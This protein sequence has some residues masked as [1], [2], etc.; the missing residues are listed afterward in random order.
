MVGEVKLLRR[1]AMGYQRD[2]ATRRRVTLAAASLTV[3]FVCCSLT[4]AVRT[5]GLEGWGYLQLAAA[6]TIGL[7]AMVEALWAV[8]GI[9]ESSNRLSW[10]LAAQRWSPKSAPPTSCFPIDRP[11]ARIRAGYRAIHIESGTSPLL[12]VIFLLAAI[13]LF[14]WLRLSRLRTMKNHRTPRARQRGRAPASPFPKAY[15]SSAPANW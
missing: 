10:L 14:S 9:D 1:L 3:A 13:Y 6:I 15:N 12:P 8:W 11:P 2:L 7:A 5:S 4:V